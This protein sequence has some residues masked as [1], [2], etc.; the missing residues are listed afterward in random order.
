MVRVRVS[1]IRVSLKVWGRVRGRVRYIL[2]NFHYYCNSF[3][4]ITDSALDF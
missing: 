4:G 2:N 1:Y 3:G